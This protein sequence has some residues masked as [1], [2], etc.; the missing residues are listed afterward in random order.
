MVSNSFAANNLGPATIGVSA[1]LLGPLAILSCI[2]NYNLDTFLIRESQNY[3]IF[4]LL[5]SSIKLKFLFYLAIVSLTLIYFQH[6][7]DETLNIFFYISVT[8]LLFTWVINLNWLFCKFE[9]QII[10]LTSLLSGSI[11]TCAL[12]VILTKYYNEPYIDTFCI[13]IGNLV[14]VLFLIFNVKNLKFNKRVTDEKS[15]N[16][17]FIVKGN[18]NLFLNYFLATVY[19]SVDLIF[20]TKIL[21]SS[22][23]GVYRIVILVGN[24]MSIFFS[25]GPMLLYP[26]FLAQKKSYEHYVK[27]VNLIFLLFILLSPLFSFLFFKYVFDTSYNTGLIPAIILCIARTLMFKNSVTSVKLASDNKDKDLLRCSIYACILTLTTLSIFTAKYGL[28]GVV[29]CILFTEIFVYFI[30]KNS[31]NK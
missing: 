19:T 16:I 5:K 29:S 14:A 26:K 30:M 3:N 8:V 11:T 20:V 9:K 28:Y 31:I 21:D 7:H 1:L 15:I 23:A 22:T 17:I 4:S 18:L 12:I 13:A 10:N 2:V 25:I 6:F 24:A 27:S